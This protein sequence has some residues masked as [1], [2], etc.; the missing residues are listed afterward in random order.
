MKP[1]LALVSTCLVLL[2]SCATETP[3]G[4]QG[5]FSVKVVPYFGPDT[6]V[7]IHA[8]ERVNGQR[9]P[10]LSSSVVKGD[11]V[12]G[13]VLPLDK[14]YGVRA[15][16]DLDG[17]GRSNTGDAVGNLEGLRPVS[18]VNH[19]AP[20]VILTLPGAGVAPDWPGTKPE[21]AATASPSSAF[22]SSTGDLLQK[23][24]DQ[25]KEAAPGLPVPPLPVPPPPPAR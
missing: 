13:F 19:Q 20:P 12:T 10:A 16:A 1:N 17:N 21:D 22:S 8:Y 3:R 9:G 25:V 18:D 6:K 4:P 2:A 5:S 24:I 7:Y 15:Y 23:G 14:E 11:G